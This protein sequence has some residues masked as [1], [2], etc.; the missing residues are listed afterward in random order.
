LASHEINL[1]DIQALIDLQ[2]A[3]RHFTGHVEVEHLGINREIR[4]SKEWINGCVLRL[5]HEMEKCRQA[6]HQAEIALSHCRSQQ[7]R[8]RERDD[9]FPSCSAEEVALRQAEIRLLESQQDLEKARFWRSQFQSAWDEYHREEERLVSLMQAHSEKTLAE[10]SRLGIRYEAVHVS[11]QISSDLE[12]LQDLSAAQKEALKRRDAALFH[13]ATSALQLSLIGAIRPGEWAVSDRAARL[14]ALQSVEDCMAELQRRKSFTIIVEKLPP[15]T[16]GYLKGH[17][18][19]LNSS[20]FENSQVQEVVDTIV[21]E[22]RH[23]YQR[24]VVDHPG[25]HLDADLVNSWKTNFA[26]YLKPEMYGYKLYKNQ[27]LEKDAFEYAEK[28]MGELYR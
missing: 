3:I 13:L 7:S 27:P 16:M 2:E 5:T 19:F 15:A 9:S 1:H 18:I 17:H 22:G 21:H 26:F 25:F 20:V 14:R 23:A 10:L 6:V 11:E 28:I 4:S 12:S 24:Y 8:D